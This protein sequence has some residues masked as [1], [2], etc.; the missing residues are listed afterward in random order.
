[1]IFLLCYPKN[2]YKDCNRVQLRLKSKLKVLSE[3]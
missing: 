2:Y 1:M 3:G